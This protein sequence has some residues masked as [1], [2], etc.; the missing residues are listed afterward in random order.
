MQPLDQVN[1][2]PTS[3]VRY[4]H[5]SGVGHNSSKCEAAP[6]SVSADMIDVTKIVGG[7]ALEATLA[8]VPVV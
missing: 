3:V 4:R 8:Q 6:F 7:N 1:R 5:F 2:R